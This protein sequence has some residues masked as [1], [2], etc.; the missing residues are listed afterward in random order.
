MLPADSQTLHDRYRLLEPLGAGGMGAVYRAADRLTGQTVALKRVLVAPSELAFNSRSDTADFPVMLA[1][2][3]QILAS[4]RH[5]NIVSAIDYGFDAQ[6]QPFFTMKL[7]ESPR[8]I[9]HAAVDQTP[10]EKMRLLLELFSALAYLHRRGILHRDLK[11]GNVLV[12]GGGQVQLLDFGLALGARSQM[13]MSTTA[14]GTLAYMA[15]E[16][17][18][19]EPPSVAS[20]LYAAGVIAYEIFKGQPPFAH[21]HIAGLITAILNR[22]PDVTGIDE[23]IAGVLRKLLA[24]HPADRYGSVEETV[25]ALCRAA[26][27][28]LPAES[29]A[30]RDSFL[31]ASQFVGRDEEFDQ[32]LRAMGETMAGRGSAWLVG[33]ESGVGKSRL[34]D[35]IR[36]RALVRGALVL[37]GQAVA[38]GGL[39]YQLW[40]EPLRR[41]LLSAPVEDTDAAILK[42]VVPDIGALLG[43]SIPDAPPMDGQ[44][45]QRRLVGAVTSL[46]RRHTGPVLLLLEDLHWAEESLAVLKPLAGITGEMRL[47]IVATYRD[48]ER[49]NLPDELPGFR[50]IT[51]QRLSP[52]SVHV[53]SA[54]MLGEAGRQPAVVELLQRETEG[55]A[56]FLVEVV[57]A[58]AEEAGRLTDIGR[59]T[60]PQRVL[61]GGV[62][63]VVRRRLGRL[64]ESAR[65]LLKRMAVAGRELDEAVLKYLAG[66]LHVDTEAW[67]TACANAAVIN[68]QD[69]KWRFAHDKLREAILTELSPDERPALHRE[70]AQTVEAAHPND[71]EYAGTLVYYWREAGDP[72]RERHY[73]HVAYEAARRVGNYRDMLA[74]AERLLELP[75]PDNPRE[76]TKAKLALA[77]AYENIQRADEAL[78]LFNE[79]IGTAR[80]QADQETL[81]EALRVLG[82]M[83]WTQGKLD[84]A[85]SNLQEALDIS[86]QSRGDPAVIGKIYQSLGTIYLI[87]A[88]YEEAVRYYEQAYGLLATTDPATASGTLMNWGVVYERKGQIN[89]ALAN[90]E[91]ALEGF[92]A[93]GD[94][95]GQGISLANIGLAYHLI[96]EF[97][98]EKGYLQQYLTISR[99]LGS[100][101]HESMAFNN[102]GTLDRDEGNYDSAMSHFQRVLEMEA[103]AGENYYTANNYQARGIVYRLQGD[104]EAALQDFETA[105]EK[106]DS[107]QNGICMYSARCQAAQIHLI[108]NRLPEALALVEAA[109]GHSPENST[110]SQ[111]LGVVLARLNRLEEARTRFQFVVQDAEKALEQTPNLYDASYLRAYALAALALVTPEDTSLLARA[112]EAYRAAHAQIQ[113]KGVIDEQ[114]FMLDLLEPLDSDGR[115]TDI[116][117]LLKSK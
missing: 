2:E 87:R 20:D 82:I 81:I 75:Q 39:S 31:Q 10:D 70:V 93:L 66:R 115:L 101:L 78:V 92:R 3:F 106:A 44:A 67:L 21:A 65:P 113:T 98:T 86:L 24:K 51:L 16:L 99:E 52:E 33:G 116:R 28:P 5:P 79:V 7:L 97:E 50:Q 83:Q 64:P 110:V 29:G 62:Q 6:E 60:L 109:D 76:Q 30:V 8:S 68:S 104:L 45:R 71:P 80:A 18:S 35:E 53:L 114:L 59:T 85:M 26:G 108:F 63:Q 40:R 55:N 22:Q 34:L 23:P 42:E 43:R 72:Q 4:L 96:G 1:R 37:R 57:R 88:Q 100:P 84:D 74:Y 27:L 15:P 73:I 36:I 102:L 13:D 46:F 48:E 54:S 14:G 69:G 11:P 89:N 91:K 38:E 56:F 17:F 90:Y 112:H 105:V 77:R 49:P 32:L 117:L 61:A 47:L 111:H 107:L 95:Y 12:T 19:E 58:L 41:L 25:E 103:T 94:R 9:T